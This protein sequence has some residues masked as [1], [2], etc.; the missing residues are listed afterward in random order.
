[1]D[2]DF[3]E[4]SYGY[5]AIREAEAEL[6]NIY[7][8]AGAPVLPS[9]LQEEKLGWD[10]KLQYV[11]YCL[12]LQFKRV[13]YVSRPHPASPTWW[14]VGGPHYRFSIDTD[15]HQHAALVN[16]EA[17]LDTGEDPGHIYYAAPGFHRQHEFD[18]AYSYGGVLERSHL[19]SPSEFPNSTG[20]HHFV[21]DLAGGLQVLSEPRRLERVEQWESMR[22]SVRSRAASASERPRSRDM[23]LGG[24]EEAVQESLGRLGR[25]VPR[26][27]DA[28]I[29]RQL[30]RSAAVLGCGLILLLVDDKE[31]LG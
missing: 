30:Q 16:L 11:E 20:R 21:A 12:F 23:T 26:T 31:P 13:E 1:M 15:G 5:A 7:R 18:D 22:E 17:A 24:L 4:F 2:C 27:I 6:A 9:L 28:P 3:S 14:S 29:T 19:V 8:S 25:D 10:A